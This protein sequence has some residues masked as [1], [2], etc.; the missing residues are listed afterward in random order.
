MVSDGSRTWPHGLKSAPGS[1]RITS[2]PLPN[3]GRRSEKEEGVVRS[4]SIRG[5]LHRAWY[6]GTY[7]E[8]RARREAWT[9]EIYHRRGDEK[10]Q[11]ENE[12]KEISQRKNTRQID[13]EE[14]NHNM[15]GNPRKEN[16]H[17]EKRLDFIPFFVYWMQSSARSSGR[18]D[19]LRINSRLGGFPSFRRGFYLLKTGYIC[20]HK[21]TIFLTRY[22]GQPSKHTEYSENEVRT[23]R[24]CSFF[25]STPRRFKRQIGYMRRPD[26][27][28]KV[29]T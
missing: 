23:W 27:P 28:R 22:S 18:T 14:K 12:K 16:R 8:R 10:V 2:S 7:S 15:A 29:L 11:G 17:F 4:G 24:D 1:A 19:S 3:N 13:K 9:F 26:F 5:V 25:I 6:M 21:L 20:K